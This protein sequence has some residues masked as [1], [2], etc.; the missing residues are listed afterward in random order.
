M[1]SWCCLLMLEI[2]L[3]SMLKVLIIAVLFMTSASLIKFIFGKFCVWWFSIYINC[4]SKEAILKT[5]SIA[6]ILAIQS[7]QRDKKQ[8][9]F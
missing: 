1:V 4:I 7:E 3:L 9:I 8:K 5:E 6:L 2:K